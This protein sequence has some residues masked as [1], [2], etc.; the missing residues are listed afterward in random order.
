MNIQYSR[1]LEKKIVILYMLA[2][3]HISALKLDTA[4]L[5]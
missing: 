4:H 3:M 1:V 2:Y 5:G